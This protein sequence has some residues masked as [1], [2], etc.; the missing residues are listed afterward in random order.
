MLDWVDIVPCSHFHC[1]R[2][3]QEQTVMGFIPSEIALGLSCFCKVCFFA[4]IS[5][6]EVS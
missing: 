1:N 3:F 2:E 5:V 4:D 6:I